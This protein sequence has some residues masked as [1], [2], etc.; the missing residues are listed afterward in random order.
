MQVQCRVGPDRPAPLLADFRLFH[1]SDPEEARI[2]MSRVFCDHRL[3][4]LG[5]RQRIDAE[6]CYRPI[7]GIGIGCMRYGANVEIDP[8]QLETFALVQMPICGAELIEHAGLR[9]NSRPDMASVIS[10]TRSLSMWHGAD[11]EKLFV[12][13]E[14]VALERHC[15]QL[16]GGNPCEPVE[17]APH[18]SM[19]TPQLRSWVRLMRWLYD[20]C[21][22]AGGNDE[23]LASPL[24]AA[25]IE[26]MVI[27]TLL[28]CQPNNYS[29]RLADQGPAVAPYFVRRV[30]DYIEEHAH[31]PVTIGDLAERAGVSTRSLFSGFRK[32]RNTTPMQYLTSVRMERVRAELQAAAPETTTVTSVAMNWGFTHLGR[33]TANYKRYFGE[34]PSMTLHR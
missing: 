18:M 15:R 8:G 20:E 27:T 6:I 10:P 22:R 2:R 25:Q 17:F 1:T 12:K 13:I 7:R 28:L 31:E 29:E 9:V 16:L 33:F 14:R 5:G 26:Q 32:Y 24:F 19:T 23:G 30:E 21:G 34:S 11:T 3:R 4:V